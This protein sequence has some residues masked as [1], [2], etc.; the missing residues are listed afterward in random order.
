MKKIAKKHFTLTELLIITAV[1]A[2]FA[3]LL[4]PAVLKAQESARAV[5]CKDNLKQMGAVTSLY[6]ADNKEHY[7]YLH[8]GWASGLAPYVD[9]EAVAQN[10]RGLFIRGNRT[11]KMFICP[12]ATKKPGAGTTGRGK[13]GINYIGNANILI[14]PFPRLAEARKSGLAD[15]SSCTRSSVKNPERIL[16]Y[17]D[18]ADMD[19]YYALAD[20]TTHNR[21]GYRH[22]GAGT[23]YGQNEAPQSSGVNAVTCSG[24]VNTHMGSVTRTNSNYRLGVNNNS[25][26]WMDS[27]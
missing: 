14:K 20:Q 24:A 25:E 5:T 4:F 7:P 8:Y 21:I 23:P 1:T 3:G 26:L 12:D 19:T 11:V 16:L 13:D 27:Y 22:P 18:H 15:K 17:L 2:V 6:M 9:K 10:Q